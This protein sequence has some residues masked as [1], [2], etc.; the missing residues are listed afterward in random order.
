VKQ[1]QI[2][3]E[4]KVNRDKIIIHY[5]ASWVPPTGKRQV[6]YVGHEE[7]TR[8]FVCSRLL[9]TGEV[10]IKAICQVMEILPADFQL[11]EV[12][13]A[14]PQNKQILNI[15]DFKRFSGYL[16]QRHL[17]R[18]VPTHQEADEIVV[19]TQFVKELRIG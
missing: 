13:F 18:R 11:V 15:P 9:L 10:A 16:K 19:D 2:N 1:Y 5:T 3:F 4:N 14:Q 17:L 6:V 8:D 12:D 7:L